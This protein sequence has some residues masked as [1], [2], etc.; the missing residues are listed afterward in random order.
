MGRQV[1]HEITRAAGKLV[2]STIGLCLFRGRERGSPPRWPG[3]L[4]TA[5]NGFP[6]RCRAIDTYRCRAIGH[7]GVMLT[8]E[9]VLI[10]DHVSIPGVARFNV[11]P[12]GRTGNPNALGRV[13]CIE[14]S[15][16]P[17]IIGQAVIVSG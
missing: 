6:L 15:V 3:I 11:E 17:I 14:T 16:V 4:P 12:P 2:P 8:L 7:Q 13:E 9:A 10:L 5:G 1:L